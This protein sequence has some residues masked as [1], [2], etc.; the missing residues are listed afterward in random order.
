MS[1]LILSGLMVVLVAG[2]AMAADR[3]SG[4]KCQMPG[5]PSEPGLDKCV[6]GAGSGNVTESEKEWS[7]SGGKDEPDMDG[8]EG[9][10]PNS[11]GSGTR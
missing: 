2:Q 6:L 4:R 1:K 10:P 11:V 9:V 5:T 3:A 7:G 8:R